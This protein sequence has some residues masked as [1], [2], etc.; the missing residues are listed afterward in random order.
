M[1]NVKRLA[2]AAWTADEVFV[3]A[4]G[5]AE[6]VI[7]ENTGSET[8]VSLRYYGPNAQPSP[9]NVGDQHQR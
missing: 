7:V 6:G 1:A 3:S 2:S 8:L 9:P 5:A 4:K